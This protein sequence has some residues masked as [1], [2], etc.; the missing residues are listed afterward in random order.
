M[1]AAIRRVCADE[2]LRH[3]SFLH[4][5]ATRHPDL[6]GLNISP[7]YREGCEAIVARAN[8]PPVTV[9]ESLS[10]KRLKDRKAQKEDAE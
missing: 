9:E 4:Y 7:E 6:L 3:W 2:P 8:P 5:V 1:V 10:G